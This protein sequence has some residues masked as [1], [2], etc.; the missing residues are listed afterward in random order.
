MRYLA[1]AASSVCVYLF[2]V[3]AVRLFGKK[4]FSQLSITDLV[5]VLLISNAVQNAMVG[6]DTSLL[7]GLCAAGALFAI[8]ALMKYVLYRFPRLSRLVQGEEIMLVYQGR[9]LADHLRRARVTRAELEEA[10]R[11]HGLAG[12]QNIHLAVLEVDGNI[13]ILGDDAD[14][15]TKKG[16]PRRNGQ[17]PQ[18]G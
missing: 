13:S 18:A 6:S 8:N 17:G 14:A 10:A 12:V 5:F 15:S 11:E 3:A 7:G 9:V 4:E 2:I 1:I 16:K